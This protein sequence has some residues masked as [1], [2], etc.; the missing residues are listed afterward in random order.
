MNISN[1]KQT[2]KYREQTSDYQW[3]EGQERG[4]QEKGIKRY[5]LLGKINQTKGYIVQHREYSQYFII[6]LY[7]V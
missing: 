1:P 4:E 6:A 3:G 2:H 5:K 7:R